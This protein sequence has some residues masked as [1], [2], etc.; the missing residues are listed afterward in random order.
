[1]CIR[2]FSRFPFAFLVTAASALV[3]VG[4]ERIKLRRDAA[5]ALPS[6][7]LTLPRPAFLTIFDFAFAFPCTFDYGLRGGEKG[8]GELGEEGGQG[9][10]RRTTR[11]TGEGGGA[12]Q[13]SAR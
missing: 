7:H 13:M 2:H 10:G 12:G 11:A 4:E 3:E 9:Q 1:M 5:S 8:K 6:L